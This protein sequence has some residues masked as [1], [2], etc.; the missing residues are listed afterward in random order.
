MYNKPFLT[1]AL[2]ASA[3]LLLLNPAQAQDYE[4]RG[5]IYGGLNHINFDSEWNLDSDEGWFVG[6]EFPI[7]ERWA[8]AVERS[9]LDPELQALPGSSD[10]NLTRIGPNFLLQ[11]INGWQ[12]Y[13]AAGVGRA[14]LDIDAGGGNSELT[15]DFGVGVKKFIDDNWFGR[16]DYKLIRITD[17]NTWDNAVSIGIGYAFGGAPSRPV[18]A[19]PAAGVVDSR[20]RC[21]N[22]P[23]E[24]AVDAN[25][26]PILE[27]QQMSQQLLVNFDVDKSDIKPEYNDEIAAFAQFMTT[28]A[29]TSV[30]I[31]GHT[32][33][34]GSDAYNQALSERRARAVMNH[35]VQNH[36][37]AASR[38]SAVGYGEG[39]PVADNANAANKARNRRIMA[40]VSV[41]VQEERRR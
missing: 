32:D 39:R 22:T 41:E 27:T 8:L 40:E 13:L 31:E 34:D 6:G 4:N 19:A 14:K 16:A 15:W 28:Y 30:V 7:A 24:L 21:A 37:I 33:S 10:F 5:N 2:L 11:N 38:L 18:A 3:G 35:L 12:P 26:C 23:R 1:R 29:N 9:K 36:G 20:D 17:T 25:G